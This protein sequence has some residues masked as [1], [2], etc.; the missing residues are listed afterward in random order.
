MAGRVRV[1]A[2]TPRELFRDTLETTERIVASTQALRAQIDEVVIAVR[3]AWAAA[4]AGRDHDARELLRRVAPP[5]VAV[6]I[7]SGD[8]LESVID[9]LDEHVVRAKRL[10]AT[11]RS[12]VAFADRA[13]S[14]AMRHVRQAHHF[15]RVRSFAAPMRCRPRSRARRRISRRGTRCSRRGPPRQAEEPPPPRPPGPLGDVWSTSLT[16]SDSRPKSTV[17]VYGPPATIGGG[18]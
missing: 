11:A 14:D 18:A 2:T 4:E 7:R 15:R 10:F 5:G 16:S 17:S 12:A 9:M 1:G 8:S 3:A 6:A 13:N